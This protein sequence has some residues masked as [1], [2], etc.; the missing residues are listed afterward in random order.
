MSFRPTVASAR[1]A[2][3]TSLSTFK[4]NV[5]VPI[6]VKLPK[7]ATTSLEDDEEPDDLAEGGTPSVCTI[8]FGPLRTALKTKDPRLEKMEEEEVV[9]FSKIV[10]TLHCGHSFHA[11]CLGDTF[12]LNPMGEALGIPPFIGMTD[13]RENPDSV[14]YDGGNEKGLWECPANRCGEVLID[15]DIGIHGRYSG[16]SHRT[17]PQT[18]DA[19]MATVPDLVR[20]EGKI[21]F[22]KMR[23]EKRRA[24]RTKW[25]ADLPLDTKL[26][27]EDNKEEAKN[28]ELAL[29]ARR[30][31]I[32]K[33]ELSEATKQANM[34]VAK[35]EADYRQERESKNEVV[36]KLGEERATRTA[37]S[38]L[39]RALRAAERLKTDQVRDELA[40]AQRSIKRVED[41]L[42]GERTDRER[43]LDATR[44]EYDRQIDQAFQRGVETERENVRRAR[45]NELVYGF[46]ENDD[47]AGL[48]GIVANSLN[49]LHWEISRGRTAFMLAVEQRKV[50][51]YMYLIT[52]GVLDDKTE[53]VNA[54]EYCV[55]NDIAE[56]MTQLIVSDV[57][58]P[59]GEFPTIIWK[60]VSA[61][62]YNSIKYLAMLPNMLPFFLVTDPS[63]KGK[64]GQS[65]GLMQVATRLPTGSEEMVKLLGPILD[66]AR[67]YASD[68]APSRSASASPTPGESDPSSS[69]SDDAGLSDEQRAERDRLAL[70]MA[71]KAAKEAEDKRKRNAKKKAKRAEAADN[72]AGRELLQQ[73][74]VTDDTPA[75]AV[76]EI[77]MESALE[78]APKTFG[79]LVLKRFPDL[80]KKYSL[81]LSLARSQ[82]MDFFPLAYIAYNISYVS[83]SIGGAAERGIIPLGLM[84]TLNLLSEFCIEAVKIG[85]NLSNTLSFKQ[86]TQNVF[87]FLI[88]HT[89]LLA[90]QIND[91]WEAHIERNPRGSEGYKKL[92]N[93]SIADEEFSELML[94][95]TFLATKDEQPEDPWPA[96]MLVWRSQVVEDTR[97]A[98]FEFWD[99][100][101][102]DF[103]ALYGVALNLI[104]PRDYLLYANSI[105]SLKATL[106]LYI[107]MLTRLFLQCGTQTGVLDGLVLQI[108]DEEVTAAAERRTRKQSVRQGR[109]AIVTSNRRKRTGT[110]N[111]TVY[112]QTALY[113][114]LSFMSQGQ[115]ETAFNMFKR[116]F[117]LYNG[118]TQPDQLNVPFGD[119][120]IPQRFVCN[121]SGMQM[122]SYYCH[123]FAIE[124]T[125]DHLLGG[126]SN[127]LSSMEV[128]S[129]G[130]CVH[131]AFAGY[132]YMASVARR[133][134]TFM[135]RTVE[136][137]QN[138][139][140]D[141]LFQLEEY[142][143]NFQAWHQ[144]EPSQPA[145][146][147][148]GLARN[149]D[150]ADPVFT[151][152]VLVRM[153]DIVSNAAVRQNIISVSGLRKKYTTLVV[154]K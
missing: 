95:G 53:L 101:I 62:A 143:A 153:G 12:K 87:F 45:H 26:R 104:I 145:N 22:S 89:D 146:D 113:N 64:K 38:A 9:R 2:E 49:N 72:T 136:T 73:E 88:Q 121:L 77:V 126:K 83:G 134:G 105:V 110:D 28:L 94:L 16:I 55:A 36:E 69:G 19:I 10:H 27:G 118:I 67:Q 93:Q 25:I 30:I 137:L 4:W 111:R 140:M 46:I 14:D 6:G 51:C 98:F 52:Q 108:D 90:D 148:I 152:R 91:L 127:S 109:K 70:N 86:Q 125:L 54:V 1:K 35:L 43:E 23:N 41:E 116:L 84:R 82:R 131:A 68:V 144:V 11:D 96:E 8:C 119:G 92:L 40:Q 17:R 149:V 74:G 39:L 63:K 56:F 99:D 132:R 103:K 5:C 114:I 33:G 106:R 97:T 122:A 79:E 138:D 29:E 15:S 34:R 150:E 81:R 7:Q 32:E 151:R 102:Y 107:S 147:P 139:F 154:D 66:S 20:G 60:L 18:E 128:D 24:L 59:G 58:P 21:E 115:E 47:V 80:N 117:P 120:D 78:L 112:E 85:C 48:G 31:Q 123:S 76:L 133:D 57:V 135:T 75:T 61:N 44:E 65:W 124:F 130:Y 129:E 142:G 3:A 50:Q 141:T 13:K 42:S 37:E 71:N 100:R